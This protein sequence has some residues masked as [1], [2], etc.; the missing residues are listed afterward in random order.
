M[1]KLFFTLMIFSFFAVTGVFGQWSGSSLNGNTY[2]NGKVGIGQSSPTALLHIKAVTQLGLSFPG[3]PSTYTTPVSLRLELNSNFQNHYWDIKPGSS[4]NFLSG[5]NTNSM[6]QRLSIGS[7]VFDYRGNLL[8][9]GTGENRFNIGNTTA[10]NGNTGQYIAF[11]ANAL[12]SSAWQF[13]GNSTNNGGAII[14]GDNQGNLFFITRSTASSN[15]MPVNQTAQ[16]IKMQIHN[17]G[18][19]SI[20]TVATEPDMNVDG[21]DYLLFVKGG[22]LSEEVTVRSGWADYVFDNNYKLL[23]LEKVKQHIDTYGHL[24]NTPSTADLNGKVNL[25]DATVQ[26][27]EKIEEIYLHLIE[28]NQEIKALKAEN[29]RL[30]QEIEDLK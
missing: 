5:T 21:D 22:T 28:M 26:Q 19:V 9:I 11:G 6:T 1:K 23:P 30:K 14:Q 18:K 8:R 16:N 29:E 4:L 17:D 15:L 24:H 27:Q 3:E 20:G 2:R 12:S 25:G 13:I 7:T 10:P